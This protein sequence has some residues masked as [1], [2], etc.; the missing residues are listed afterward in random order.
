MKKIEDIPENVID[1]VA[2]TSFIMVLLLDGSVM[3]R[4]TYF[5]STIFQ[6][7]FEKINI[8]KKITKIYNNGNN[9][10]FKCDDGT[11]IDDTIQYKRSR[12]INGKKYLYIPMECWIHCKVFKKIKN[13]PKNIT[14]FLW[15]DSIMIIR[16]ENNQLMCR[17]KGSNRF[18]IDNNF[19][20]L[21]NY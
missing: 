19:P 21:L 7:T 6:R 5:Y 20:I 8:G 18:T 17:K 2:N 13:I 14:E 3:Y 11:L 16:L 4:G 12:M 10:V 9:I 1:V 15:N